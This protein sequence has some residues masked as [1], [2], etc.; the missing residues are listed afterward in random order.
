[1]GN[2]CYWHFSD[3]PRALQLLI[4]LV[5]A[6][7]AAVVAKKLLGVAFA[8]PLDGGARF[9][10]G[11]PIFDLPSKSYQRR[12]SRMIGLSYR[13]LKDRVHSDPSLLHSQFF[14]RLQELSGSLMAKPML[15]LFLKR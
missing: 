8:R 4:L 7:G 11:Q 15:F 3:I 14:Q 13:S 12:D 2:V 1:L 5:V 6:N 9:V 10:D